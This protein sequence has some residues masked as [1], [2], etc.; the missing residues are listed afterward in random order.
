MPN[1]LLLTYHAIGPGPAPLCVDLELF[2]THADVIA[3]SGRRCV[4]VR[5]LAAEL[6]TGGTHEPLVALTFDDGFASV[7]EAAVPVLLDRGLTATVYCVGGHL[8]GMSDWH[9]LR[10]GAF[11]SRLAGAA[12]LADVASHGI[13]IG[14][15]GVRHTPLTG[16]DDATLSDEVVGSRVLLEDTVGTAIHTFAYP[17]GALPS[18][19]GARMVADVYDAACTTRLSAVGPGTLPYFLPRVDVHYVQEES[20]LERALEGTLDRY[21]ALRGAAARARRRMR[22][23]YATASAGW[24]G[25]GLV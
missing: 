20:M 2:R 24:P 25:G 19:R 10:P 5:E 14:S 11:V 7:V 17:Y 4:T 3:A 15:H 18:E 21:L 13:E 6:A 23:D 9:S 8:G 1:A 12:D 16:A 22:K